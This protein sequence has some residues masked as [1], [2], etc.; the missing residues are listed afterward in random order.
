MEAKMAAERVDKSWQKSG[1]D[2]FSTEAIL[3]SLVHYGVDVD[4]AGFRAQ[5]AEKY[6]LHIA[7]SWHSTWKGTGQFSKFPYAAA[8]E[9][10]LRLEK[11][12]LRP[13]DFADALGDLVVALQDL[14]AGEKDAPVDAGFEKVRALQPKLPSEKAQLEGLMEE[15][16]LQFGEDGTKVFDEIA[17]ELAKEGHVEKAKAFAELEEALMPERRGIAMATVRAAA[18][19]RDAAIADVEKILSEPARNTASRLLAVDA[20]IHMDAHEPAEKHASKALDE[21]EKS[22]DW[23]L[24]LALCDRLAHLLEKLGRTK[25]LEALADRAERLAAAHDAAHPHHH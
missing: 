23:H 6:P 2:R 21:A 25:D 3:G 24:A 5:A 10:W 14:N 11:D 15:V 7:H 16:M 12:R 9:L 4:E 22:E 8:N 20:L 1:L 17:E 13:I 18:G 19:E